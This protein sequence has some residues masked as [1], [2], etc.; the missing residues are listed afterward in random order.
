MGGE[1]DEIDNMIGLIE[2]ESGLENAAAS[3]AKE[4]RAR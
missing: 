4:R 3:V 2:G 1:D